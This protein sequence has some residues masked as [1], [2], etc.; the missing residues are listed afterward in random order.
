VKTPLIHN[1]LDNCELGA[2]ANPGNGT[3]T[4]S[5][6]LAVHVPNGPHAS[7]VLRDARPDGS[8]TLFLIQSEGVPGNAIDCLIPDATLT[9]ND[10]GTGTAVIRE[11]LSP[12]AAYAH[13]S[14]FT[15]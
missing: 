12:G 11:S 6:A 9:T 14:L 4:S 7:V 2:D 8:Y 15:W 1:P 3:A 10:A 5:V 13:V